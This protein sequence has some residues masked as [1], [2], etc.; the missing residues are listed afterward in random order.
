M[1]L[2]AVGFVLMAAGGELW[3]VLG[4]LIA[5]G[6]GWGWQS[7][8]SLAV[9]TQYRE[10]TAVA[11]GIQ[12]SGFFAGAVVG[13]LA[14]GVLAED[15]GYTTAWLLGAALAA[16]AAMAALVA[17]RLALADGLTVR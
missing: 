10:T 17:R 6:V 3:I 5:G 7:P 4:A 13:P 14:I 15:G 1:A 12:M 2:C 9:V 16:A 8:L 11:V